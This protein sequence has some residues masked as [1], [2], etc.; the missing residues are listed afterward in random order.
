MVQT[1]FTS[2]SKT[3]LI[4]VVDSFLSLGM[5]ESE[6]TE[7]SIDI[8]LFSFT[9]PLIFE[10]LKQLAQEYPEIQVRIIADWGNVSKKDD[11][12]LLD[13]LPYCN[14]NFK[15]KFK[16][17]QPYI[18]DNDNQKLRWRYQASLGLLH[19]KTILIRQAKVPVKL[20]SGSF[21]WTKTAGINYE[22]LMVL[23]ATTKPIQD[24]MQAFG[25]EF[26][27]L[28]KTKELTL[29]YPQAS[30][31][32]A[33]ILKTYSGNPELNSFQVAHRLI[34][35][36]TTVD[37]R[38]KCSPSQPI[39]HDIMVAFSANHPYKGWR[40]KGFSVDNAY[41]YFYMNKPSGLQVKVPLDIHTT[42]LS[43]IYGALPD[44]ELCL[45]MFAISPRVPEYTALLEAAR[46]G[47][48]MRCI[49]DR[50]TN[51]GMLVK[52]KELAQMEQLPLQV[53]SGTRAMHQKYLVNHQAGMLITGTANMSTD[54][55]VRHAEHRFYFKNSKHITKH[56]QE[57]FDTI[58]QRI[59]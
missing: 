59:H 27:A 48:R 9:S 43:V 29:D 31:Y 34:G 15:I 13:L 14:S 56:F 36:R 53:K 11:R 47:V 55:S 19:H 10:R 23:A 39:T 37:D 52:I 16:V 20:L 38:P 44:Q 46:K 50:N 51:K 7:T 21:N 24:V 41:R 57:D 58:W 5:T 1:Y 17:D 33:T 28:W 25:L 8:M 54:S 30:L 32:R 18:W 49:L 6:T 35:Q 4:Q 45:C 40:N 22:N 3:P 42:A 26:N 2:T 12:K